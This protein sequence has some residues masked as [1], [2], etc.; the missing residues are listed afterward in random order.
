MTTT[1]TEKTQTQTQ[2]QTQISKMETYLKEMS[3]NNT[4]KKCY[5]YSQRKS[6]G[7]KSR[8]DSM[9][10]PTLNQRQCVCCLDT[11][12]YTMSAIGGWYC[13]TC[14]NKYAYVKGLFA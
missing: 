8:S 7:E 11:S 1:I 3:M 12:V 9:I 5:K 10:N 13:I 2:T 14:N 4:Q 6:L